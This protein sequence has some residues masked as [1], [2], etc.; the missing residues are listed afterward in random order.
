MVRHDLYNESLTALPA[1]CAWIMDYEGDRVLVLHNFSGSEINFLL[2]DT[3]YGAVAVQ[4][5]VFMNESG[6]QPRL[7]MGPYSSVVFDL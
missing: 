7:M 5:D 3:V 1:L 2:H 4:G 6:S